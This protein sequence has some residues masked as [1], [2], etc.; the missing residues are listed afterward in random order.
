MIR[1]ETKNGSP[2][3]RSFTKYKEIFDLQKIN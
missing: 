1:F 3:I 2:E